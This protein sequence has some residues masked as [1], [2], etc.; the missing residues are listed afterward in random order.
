MD[1]LLDFAQDHVTDITVN[2]A[3][4]LAIFILARLAQVREIP[5]LAIAA[6]P[7][8][9]AI[10]YHNPAVSGFVAGLMPN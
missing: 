7:F 1:T 10:I 9:L 2:F 8:A 5:A 3:V 4:F 6:A